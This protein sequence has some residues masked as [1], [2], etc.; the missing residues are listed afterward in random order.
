MF[1]FFKKVKHRSDFFCHKKKSNIRLFWQKLR[2]VATF[3]HF[4]QKKITYFSTKFLSGNFFD[5]VFLSFCG[6][7]EQKNNFLMVP[8]AFRTFFAQITVRRQW[9]PS[10]Q[11]LN[12]EDVTFLFSKSTS[13]NQN[14]APKWV[15]SQTFM[16][17]EKRFQGFPSTQKQHDFGANLIN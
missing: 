7:T 10:H 13:H 12:R 16:Q 3:V 14:K 17:R 1:D 9:S 15:W 11:D 8:I 4:G 6:R 2:K 5:G